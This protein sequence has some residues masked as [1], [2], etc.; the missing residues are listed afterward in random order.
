MTRW[1]PGRL[2]E[3]TDNFGEGEFFGSEGRAAR[4]VFG[5]GGMFWLRDGAGDFS[6]R[7]RAAIGGA[8]FF[9]GRV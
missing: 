4:K 8:K 2:Q 5:E 3:D 7:G 9:W 6:G 1:V